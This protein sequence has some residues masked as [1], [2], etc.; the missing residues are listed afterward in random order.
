MSVL[1]QFVAL[2]YFSRFFV[3][4]EQEKSGN[5]GYSFNVSNARKLL[6]RENHNYI[7]KLQ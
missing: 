4:L 3:S 1:E 7:K 5:P 6:A 2:W